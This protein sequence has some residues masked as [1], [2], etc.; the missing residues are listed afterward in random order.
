MQTKFHTPYDGSST[1]YTIALKPLDP[2]EW[3]EADKRLA[4]ECAAILSELDHISAARKNQET[5]P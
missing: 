5:S 3:I 4:G 2:D 1:L